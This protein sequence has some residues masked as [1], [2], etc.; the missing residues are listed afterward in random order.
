[1]KYYNITDILPRCP[2]VDR[3]CIADKCMAWCNRVTMDKNS[4]KFIQVKDECYCSA[5]FKG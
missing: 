3:T 5:L 2:F 1:M 4:E